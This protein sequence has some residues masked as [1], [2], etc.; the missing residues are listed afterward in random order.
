[1]ND[2]VIDELIV[3]K[4]SGQ[5]VNFNG[6][7]IALAIKNAFDSVDDSYDENEVNK[8]YEDTLKYIVDNYKDRKTINV[9]D[10]QDIIE[11]IL[12][13][14]KY[15]VIYKSFS[16]YRIRRSESRKA[17]S[18]KQ[19]HKFVKAIEKIG[20]T[21]KNTMNEL[22]P[23]EVLTN[24]GNIVSDEFTKSYIID[25]KTMRMFDEGK[26]Y[27]HNFS[28]FNL[29]YVM[30]THL[31]IKNLKLNNCF[32]YLT[33]LL[34]K[35]TG[36]INGEVS[37]CEF[38]KLLSNVLLEK[39]KN[40]FKYNLK[41]YFELMDYIE[42]LNI[43]K[44]YELIDKSENIT[45]DFK[46]FDPYILGDIP[47]KVIKKAY[48][49]SYNETMN[50]FN[51]NMEIFLKSVNDYDKIKFSFSL[52]NSSDEITKLLRNIILNIINRLEYL[53]NIALIYKINKDD[54][55]DLMLDLILNNK[56]IYIVFNNKE[57]FSD[58]YL[59]HENNYN[60]SSSGGRMMVSNISLN[61]C[62]L[63]LIHKSV[64]SEFYNDLDD[65]LSVINSRLDFFVS[66]GAVI[67]DQSFEYFPSV[68]PTIEEAR[69]LF[70]K[71]DTWKDADYEAFLGF[72]LTYLAKEYK[73][74]D[75]TMQIHFD[76]TRNVNSDEFK[77]CGPDTGF[78]IIS[79]PIDIKNVIKFLNNIKD[80]ERPN[81]ILY[82]LNDENLKALACLTGAFRNVSIG[83]AWWFN[84]TVL[85]IK[86]NLSVIAEYSFLG[87]N[88]GMLTDS[89]SFAS[90]VRF[91][92]FRRVLA[93]Y[94]GELV[95]NGEYDENSAI[96][97][98]TN[99]SYKNAN[100]LVK[101]E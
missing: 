65:L 79:N 70:I 97:L 49:D 22:L 24:F 62:R 27:I 42:Y 5:R 20:T 99:I 68:Y 15:L 56:N 46:T 94:I 31:M 9:E 51:S 92:L 14:D 25:S 95:E 73:K 8:V 74:H 69:A 87:N 21:G 82:T 60:E 93:S 3:V 36:E 100:K 6:L 34:I 39:F 40:S 7:K 4:R 32:S 59:I 61:M 66:K 85:G 47:K 77:V 101:G 28:Y 33:E 75:M 96:E 18:V 35:S 76:V 81:I 16:E 64:N 63:F 55:N 67:S 10:I 71:R 43:R 1:M 37:I 72:M 2:H 98:A 13:Q 54:Y 41:K 91:D 26:I 88:M 44:I 30:N 80:E 29:G 17:F 48:D 58:G 50:Y 86:H 84:D 90:Y 19:Q 38:D 83:P 57:Y 89:R 52:S 23:R 45:I 12:K 78:D 53:K 11:N